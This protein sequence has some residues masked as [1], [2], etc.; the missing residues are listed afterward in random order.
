MS[1]IVAAIVFGALSA[2]VHREPQQPVFAARTSLVRVDVSVTERGRPV[3]GL[4][5][6]DFDIRDNGVPQQ[7]EFV[8][9]ERMPLS[10]ALVL[11]VSGSV[12]GDRLDHFRSAIDGVLERLRKDDRVALVTFSHAITIDH[13]SPSDR[14]VLHARLSATKGA[15]GTALFDASYAGL[16][17][18]NQ[19]DERGLQIV[20]SDGL[21]TAS[22]LSPARVLEIAKRTEVVTYVVSSQGSPQDRFLSDLGGLTGGAHLKVE[23]TKELESAFAS[24]LEEFRHRY[25]LSYQPTGVAAG[26]WHRIAVNVRRPGVTVKARPGY[27]SQ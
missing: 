9:T 25:L 24:I 3:N 27:L 21:D 13:A 2:G 26:G 16:T 20:F 7:V 10:V 15:G 5:P 11:D 19:A 8:L 22:W 23:S 17:L 18:A 1:R 6:V 12:A 14:G 4:R